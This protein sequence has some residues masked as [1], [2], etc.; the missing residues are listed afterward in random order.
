MAPEPPVGRDLLCGRVAALHRALRPL[1]RAPLE[2]EALDAYCEVLA[3][4]SERALVTACDRV[5][6]EWTNADGFPTPA[7]LLRASTTRRERERD[8]H[9]A[10]GDSPVL[11]AWCDECGR[12][13]VVDRAASPLVQA[14]RLRAACCAPYCWRCGGAGL[15]ELAPR[16]A[17]GAVARS[18]SGVPLA[19]CDCTQ[20]ASPAREDCLRRRREARDARRGRTRDDDLV[21]AVESLGVAPRS[22]GVLGPLV[23][24]ALRGE[25]DGPRP[26]GGELA[27]V[28][29]ARE[30]GSDDDA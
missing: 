16:D 1:A 23:R 10:P 22:A 8:A 12:E 14:Y 2:P 25:R 7:D 5:L 27:R 4:L 26:R 18:E 9:L 6:R 13:H 30:P 11:R 21:G 3:G 28:W 20:G 17:P 29:A 24:R 15:V 19:A